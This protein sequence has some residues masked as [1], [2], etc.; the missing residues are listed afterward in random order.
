MFSQKKCLLSVKSI[1]VLAMKLRSKG[2][3][4]CKN[5][6]NLDR[7]IITVLSLSALLLLASCSSGKQP[8]TS[9]SGEVGSGSPEEKASSPTPSNSGLSGEVKI[10][11][12]SSLFLVSEAMGEAFQTANSGV[13]VNVNSSSSGAGFKKFCA[14]KTDISNASR[15]IKPEEIE[16]CKKGNIEYIELPISADGIVV[17]INQKNKALAP[18]PQDK[19]VAV[20]PQDNTV[21]ATPQNKALECLKV[22]ELKKI[23]APSA[24]G[25][26]KTWNQVN[27]KFT[28]KPITLFGPDKDSGTYDFFTKTIIGAE[29]KSRTDY[30]ASQ[31]DNVLVL[32]VAADKN[33]MGFFSYPYYET[34][35]DKLKVIGIDSGKGCVNPSP[36]TINDGTYQPLSRPQFIYVKK[37]SASR[38]EVKAFVEF[39]LSTASKKLFS[40]MGYIPLP[41]ELIKE[42]QQHFA[43][44]KVGSRFE[45]KGSQ[46]GVTIKDL[47]TKE[48]KPE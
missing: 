44:G 29:G 48:K 7:R 5:K 43:E 41:E 23:W 45:G 11:G 39:L 42:V 18:N 20:N 17:V 27:S 13:K 46:V 31:D 28:K 35:K 12:S 14:G 15:P 37:E 26:I 47:M 30:T 1:S 36:E 32:N 38:P 4:N 2:V 19:T 16:L 10:D 34:N 3:N 40:E 8:L 24:E 33:A 9:A 25:S 22:E 21:V 6:A